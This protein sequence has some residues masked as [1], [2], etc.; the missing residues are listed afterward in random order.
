VSLT[1]QRGEF[2]AVMGTS[3]SGKSTRLQVNWST[4]VQ[5]QIIFIS[6]G[7]SAFVGV[8]FGL[9]PAH[10]ASGLDPIQALRFE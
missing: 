6:L 9:Y 10:K 3:G 7:F 4:I 5:P 8:G 1:V 2:V